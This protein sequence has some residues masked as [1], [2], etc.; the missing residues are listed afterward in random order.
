MKAFDKEDIQKLCAELSEEIKTGDIP[1]EYKYLTVRYID[2]NC[3]FGYAKFGEFIFNREK[4]I[5]ITQDKKYK[6]QHNEYFNK[7]WSGRKIRTLKDYFFVEAMFAGVFTERVDCKGKAIFTGD[8]VCAYDYVVSGCDRCFG[9]DIISGICSMRHYDRYALMLDNHCLF[10]D[11]ANRLEVMGNVFYN[12][13]L[14]EHDFD[15]RQNF[16]IFLGSIPLKEYL[17]KVAKAP[18]FKGESWQESVVGLFTDEKIPFITCDRVTSPRITEL[19]KND[20][21]VFGSNIEGNHFGGAAKL[22]YNEFGAQWTKGVGHYGESYAI[23]TMDGSVD[24]IEPYVNDFLNYARDYSEYRFLVT[25]VGCGIAGY[26]VAEIVPLF[27][28][29]I[30]IENVC[31]PRSFWEELNVEVEQDRKVLNFKY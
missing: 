20:V 17:K 5:L 1:K 22:A 12:I 30:E 15:I 19:E 2:S 9:R 14:F 29:A 11:D 7:D 8:V 25:E 28:R 27:Y 10:L 6:R 31:L 24:D 26:T 4:F 16:N 3:E 23:P 13:G 21:F 18:Y